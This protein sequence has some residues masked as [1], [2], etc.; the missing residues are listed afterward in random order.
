VMLTLRVG[1]RPHHVHPTVPRDTYHQFD[2]FGPLQGPTPLY[3]SAAP[4]RVKAGAFRSILA[5]DWPLPGSSSW[6]PS[7]RMGDVLGG[8]EVDVPKRMY[9][10][11]QNSQGLYIES[12]TRKRQ[13]APK[14][15]DLERL[16]ALAPR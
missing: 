4:E 2:R 8:V 15:R 7:G 10:V 11:R 16:S 1:E 3:A 13:N 9:Y 6:E 5:D 14:G 12:P